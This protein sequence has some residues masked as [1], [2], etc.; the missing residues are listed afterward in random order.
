MRH[1]TDDRAETR[2]RPQERGRSRVRLEDERFLTGQGRYVDDLDEPGQLY[3][4]VLRSPLAHGRIASLDVSDASAMPGVVAIFTAADLAAEG[5]G[6]LP[7]DVDVATDVPLV[8]PPRPALAADRVR[9]VGDPIAF[10]VAA[11]Q[12]AAQDA[13]E[14]IAVQF[15]DLP[16]VTDAEAAL[17]AGAPCVWDQAPGNLAFRFRKGDRDAVDTA[18]AAA[19]TIV[20]LTLGN[21]RVVAAALEPRA[22]IGTYD[23]AEDTLTLILTGQGVHEMRRQLADSVFHR[24]E[25]RIHLV[26]PD[27]GGGFG[28]KNMLYPE[29]VLVLFAARR[30]RKPIKWTSSRSEDFL[31]SA[32]ARDNRT[33]ARLALDHEGRFLALDVETVA[34]MG[35]Y[36]SALGPLVPTQAAASAMGGVYAI[37]AICMDVRGAF[38]NSVPVDAYRGAGKPEAN[39]LIERLV[40]IAAARIG[41]PSMDLRRLNMM[42]VFPYRSALGMTVERGAFAAHLDTA[43]ARSDQGGFAVRRAE[44]ARRGRMRGLGFG[45]LSRNRAGPA[46]GVRRRPV[47]GGWD[48]QPAPRHAIERPRSRDELSADRG[49]PARPADRAVSAGAGRHAPRGERQGARRGSVAPPGR[50][51]AGGPPSTAC[52]RRPARSRASSCNATPATSPLATDPSRG[53]GHG[54]SIDLAAVAAVAMDPEPWRPGAAPG[55]A[56][57]VENPLGPRHLPQRL[58]RGRGRDRPRDRRRDAGALHRGR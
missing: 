11:S 57:M 35:A 52:W 58:P 33:R 26:A 49:R 31:S 54:R 23:P 13:A 50:G 34:D 48:R 28:A 32:Q 16:A 9:H 30:L 56:C 51:G 6:D 42:S 21:N 36:L 8:I 15:G 12:T 14:A 19:A 20:E 37:P 47:R 24:P 25:A 2:P 45:L 18:M 3:G 53:S 5:I 27:V 7:C 44:A 39:Y 41:M 40:E 22:A 1:P 55:L 46:G 10:V 38:T 43:I 17:R 29:W 4:H